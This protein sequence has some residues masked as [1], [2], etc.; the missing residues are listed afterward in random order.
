MTRYRNFKTLATPRPVQL[1]CV[2]VDSSGDLVAAGGKDVFEVII[3]LCSIGF[4]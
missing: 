2:S 1:S 3:L 4:C